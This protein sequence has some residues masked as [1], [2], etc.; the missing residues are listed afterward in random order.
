MPWISRNLRG[1]NVFARAHPDGSLIV[2][3]SGRVDIVYKYSGSAKI[4]RAFAKNLEP[5]MG[6]SETAAR[7][8]NALLPD[9]PETAEV[10]P[11]IEVETEERHRDPKA[12]LVY[13]DGA[14]SGNPGPMGI[15][16]VLLDAGQRREISEFLGIGTNNIAELAAI[17]RALDA[18][19]PPDR[20]RTI[21]VHS[22]S[23]Y[24]IGLLARGFKAKANVELVARLRQKAS[25]FTR[26]R[27][28]KVEGHAGV[29]ENERAD[30]LARRAIQRGG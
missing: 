12:I 28:I 21:M 23:S 20:G 24:A 9:F 5:P 6:T 18:I 2:D 14:C 3:A 30:E 10:P 29:P 15:G 19:T 8:G 1:K 13:T 27:F 16:V 17:E 25:D 4:Y 7:D 11:P 22:D 26:L